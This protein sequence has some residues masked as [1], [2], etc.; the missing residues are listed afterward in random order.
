M[1]Q[2]LKTRAIF[3]QN[4]V[5][6][7]EIDKMSGRSDRNDSLSILWIYNTYS[8]VKPWYRGQTE[9]IEHFWDKVVKYHLI[10]IDLDLESKRLDLRD[11]MVLTD[12]FLRSRLK[13]IKLS[14][15]KIEIS[16]YGTSIC[17]PS[18]YGKYSTNLTS[19]KKYE[20]C[21]QLAPF[22]RCLPICIWMRSLMV[23]S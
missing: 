19:F 22:F 16:V 4:L 15:L 17:G 9:F 7:D 11:K 5:L 13:Y 2:T 18:N 1:W 10:K 21:V 20:T 23:C 12:V 3:T 6:L 14:T 8:I